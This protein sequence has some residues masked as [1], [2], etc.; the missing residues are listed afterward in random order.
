MKKNTE[1]KINWK[2]VAIVGGV[3]VLGVGTG[4]VSGKILLEYMIKNEDICIEVTNCMIKGKPGI[5]QVMKCEKAGIAL[6]MKLSRGWFENT[7]DIID[8]TLTPEKFLSR[9]F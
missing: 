9:E 4:A 3:F 1:K 5:K 8:G 7:L 6:P 2:K